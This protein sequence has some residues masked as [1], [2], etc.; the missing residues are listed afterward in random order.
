VLGG[1][2]CHVRVGQ[3][4]FGDRFGAHDRFPVRRGRRTEVGLVGVLDGV[5]RV[6]D[7]V[8]CLRAREHGGFEFGRHDVER[9]RATGPRRDRVRRT[10]GKK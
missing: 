8:A 2:G 10:G 9:C 1:L 6:A 4:G 5:S 3:C 7:P